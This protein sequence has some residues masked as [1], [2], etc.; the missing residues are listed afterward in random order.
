M[1]QKH[2]RRSEQE[3]QTLIRECRGSGLTVKEWCEQHH[4]TRN[5]F[6]HHNR[7]SRY[8]SCESTEHRLPLQPE[9]QEVV[10]SRF[11]PSILKMLSGKCCRMAG[12]LI[13]PSV[14]CSLDFPWRFRTPQRKK[15][16][17]TRSPRCGNFVR[18]TVRRRENLHHYG[19]DGYAKKL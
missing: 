11:R 16:S 19:P 9:R 13:R 15:R 14:W 8:S 12:T 18:R 5:S 7:K 10:L 3:W 2:L 1:E 6:Y 4:I 17:V